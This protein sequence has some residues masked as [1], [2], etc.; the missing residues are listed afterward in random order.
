M[1]VK[2]KKQSFVVPGQDYAYIGFGD[3]TSLDS[4]SSYEQ[5][6]ASFATNS[7]ATVPIPTP[8]SSSNGVEPRQLYA[9]PDK[10]SSGG[11]TDQ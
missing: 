2:E 9:V 10:T 8:S 3:V 5:L 11:K 7:T 4:S 1:A 6:G